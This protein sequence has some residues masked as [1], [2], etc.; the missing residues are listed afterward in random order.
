[1]DITADFEGGFLAMA[2]R[3][4]AIV[5]T[6][7]RFSTVVACMTD[8]RAASQEQ[9]FA[10]HERVGEIRGVMETLS[11]TLFGLERD[12]DVPADLIRL[13]AIEIIRSK[14]H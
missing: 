4:L 2:S 9:T 5:E 8:L 12:Y 11:R 14:D 6:D 1:M 10:S 3:D 7:E 13:R